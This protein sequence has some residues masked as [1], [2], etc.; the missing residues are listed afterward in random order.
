ML[1]AR[2]PG[3][4]RRPRRRPH[5]P[6][7]GAVVRGGARV[8]L[9]ARTSTLPAGDRSLD[10]VEAAA[11]IT[12]SE[13][14]RDDAAQTLRFFADQGVG[15]KGDLRRQPHHRGRHRAQGRAGGGEPV[16]ARTLPDA[17]DELASLVASTVA[18]GRVSPQQ[19]RAIVRALQA[20]GH[21]VAMTGDGVNDVLALKDADIGTPWAT[22]PRPPRWSPSSSCWTDGSPTC[23]T[24]WWRGAVWIGTWWPRCSS[25]RTS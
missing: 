7:R 14:V 19:E 1:A 18:P 16:D 3:G 21:T 15:V 25:A 23:R 13:H 10:D 17:P 22:P 24:S 8:V 5:A 9:L 12:L 11:L 2:A 4:A 20:N 6:R